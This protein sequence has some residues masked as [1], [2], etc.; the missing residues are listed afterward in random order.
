MTRSVVQ[1]MITWLP[2]AEYIFMSHYNTFASLVLLW[3]Q[4]NSRKNARD[5]K[6]ARGRFH[7]GHKEETEILLTS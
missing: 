3:R 6:N 1:I 5:R 2:F 4:K 7:K